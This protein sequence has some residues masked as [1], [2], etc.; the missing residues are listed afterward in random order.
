MGTIQTEIIVRFYIGL[1]LLHVQK[2]ITIIISG[3]MKCTSRNA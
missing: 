1:G 2:R 3:I